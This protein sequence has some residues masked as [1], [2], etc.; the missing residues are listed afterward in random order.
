MIRQLNNNEL[1]ASI[2]KHFGLPSRE[3]L[4]DESLIASC[5][6]RVAG[7]H[8]PCASST[9][10]TAFLKSFRYLY[11]DETTFREYINGMIEKLII[12]GDLLEFDDV[13]NDFDVKGNWIFIAHPSFLVRQNGSILVF[14]ISP[15]E[16][17]PI[18]SLNHRIHYQGCKRFLLPTADEDLATLLKG[19]GLTS[20]S[21]SVWLKLPQKISSK[22]Y[23]AEMDKRLSNAQYSGEIADLKILNSESNIK[24]YNGRW[25][26]PDKL[27]GRFLAKRPH[28]YGMV[29][30]CYVE[31]ESGVLK[32]FV[33]VPLKINGF[34]QRGCDGAWHL[35]MAIDDLRNAP[36]V[37]SVRSIPEGEIME[38]YSP[39]PLWAER[40]LMAIGQSVV[41]RDCLF[42]YL[43]NRED[44]PAEQAFL[45][46]YL[47]LQ[48]N[49]KNLS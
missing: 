31:L 19:L 12:G 1:L 43:I 13:I 23:I 29:T 33:D 35:Q 46:E 45:R 20:L 17:S 38:F 42:S 32:R 49:N 15:D 14:G 24:Y 28:V 8:C 41:P 21:E 47:W 11:N 48:C 16:D 27:S 30:W 36:Q 25:M 7:I 37:Y 3:D 34:N 26:N 6:R 39:I 9:L 40:R 18:P 22:E 44:F 4:V 2:R 10:A 5:L